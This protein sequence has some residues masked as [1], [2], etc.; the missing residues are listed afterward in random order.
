MLV[1]AAWRVI[2]YSRSASLYVDEAALALGIINH[3]LTG[4]FGRLDYGQVA[5]SGFRL[6]VKACAVVFG[7]SEWSLRLFPFLC[8]LAALPVF[9]FVAG[10]LLPRPA[11]AVATVLFSLATPVAVYSALLKPYSS[12][13]LFALIV[14]AATHHLISSTG[15]RSRLVLTAGVFAAF[16]SQAALLVLAACGVV[17]VIDALRHHRRLRPRLIVVAAWAVAVLINAWWNLSIMRAAD[18]AYMLRFWEPFFMPLEW[19][20]GV[21]WLWLRFYDLIV[22]G[23]WPNGS[24]QYQMPK[25]WAV[26]I[27]SGVIASLRQGTSGLLLLAPPIVAVAAAAAG[28]YP[29]ANRTGLFLVP[30]VLLLAVS[31]ARQ[32]VAWAGTR[33]AAIVPTLLIPLGIVSVLKFPP[34]FRPEHIR[35]SLQ[36][37]ASHL[38]PDDRVWVYYGGTRGYEY[39]TR[40]ITIPAHP[41]F[42]ICDRPD[43]SASVRQLEPL[44]GAHRA[45][46]VMTHAP[47]D[48]QQSILRR[49][50]ALGTRQDAHS[51]SDPRDR[52][53]LHAA[54]YLYQLDGQIGANAPGVES[55]RSVPGEPAAWNCY[56]TMSRSPDGDPQSIEDLE[57]QR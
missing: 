22:D 40:R 30:I 41:L 39:Y 49:L 15:D 29:L 37:M 16:F 42:S 23:P 13:V 17:V 12:D 34:H 51:A 55:L 48:E 21:Q 10:R 36:Y 14:L 19:P 9:Y 27:A 57:R 54:V 25:V 33:A 2:Q 20:A 3:D 8:G 28:A 18:R 1:G 35:P 6:A 50:D 46:I 43:T 7:E 44:R 47:L 52:S 24:L 26:L 31:G 45:W 56:G 32:L 38:Q 4:L 53:V 5:P 11:A